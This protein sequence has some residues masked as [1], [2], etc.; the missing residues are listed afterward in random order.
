MEF[1][2]GHIVQEQGILLYSVHVPFT[3]VHVHVHCTQSCNEYY[4]FHY[5]YLSSIISAPNMHVCQNVKL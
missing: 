1:V 2:Q 4:A 5:N 3:N